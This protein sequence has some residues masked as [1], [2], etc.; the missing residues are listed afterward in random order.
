MQYEILVKKMVS[1]SCGTKK[2]QTIPNI[3]VRKDEAKAL[4]L[5]VRSVTSYRK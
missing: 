4:K 5:A 2:L 3:K 1:F